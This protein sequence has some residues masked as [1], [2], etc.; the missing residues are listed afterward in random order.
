MENTTEVTVEVKQKAFDKR[1]HEVDLIRG[2]LIIFVIV[3]H[4]LNCFLLHSTSFYEIT[5]NSFWNGMYNAMVFYWNNPARTVIRWVI[6]ALFCFISGV[7]CSFSRNNWKRAAEAIFLAGIISVATNLGAS[8]GVF[9]QDI[10]IDHNIIAVIGFSTLFYCFF[11]NKSTKTLLI[12]TGCLLLF[13]VVAVPLLYNLIPG[14]KNTFIPP[15]WK[16]EEVHQGDWMPLFPYITFFFA[17]AIVSR[18][19]YKDKTSKIKKHEWERPICFLGRHTL[20]VYVTHYL[21]FMGIFKLIEAILRVA[22]RS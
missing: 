5:G 19:L 12:V 17:G 15:L 2:I 22:F 10:R 18:Y 1:I 21:I 11:Q 9:G 6:L 4:L 14:A 20:I 3:D 7:S 16:P 8:W 13:S